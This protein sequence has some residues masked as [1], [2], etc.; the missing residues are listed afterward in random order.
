MSDKYIFDDWS[1]IN[2]CDNCEHWWNSSC[3][4]VKESCNSF[5]AT[6]K[7]TI[8]QEIKRANRLLK[9]AFI[10]CFFNALILALH[11]LGEAI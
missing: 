3:D 6:R 1:D 9:W 10:L 2:Q 11:I 8:P 5:K 4:G 7:S